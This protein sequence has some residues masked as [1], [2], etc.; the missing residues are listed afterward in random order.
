[1]A[2]EEIRGER[3]RK[4][5]ALKKAGINPYPGRTD[6]RFRIADII[7]D[8]AGYEASGEEVVAAGRVMAHREQ[9]R[10]SFADLHDESGKIQLILRSDTLDDTSKAVFSNLDIGDIIEAKGKAITTKRGEKSLEASRLVMLTKTIL[11]LPDKWHGLVDIEERLRRRYLDLL[12]NP[13]ERELFVKKS[14]FWQ[15]TR[16]FLMKEGFLEVETPVLEATPGGADAEPFLTHHNALDVDFYLRI[17]PELHLKRLLTA[18]YE[19]VFEIGRIFRN[20]G[21]DKEHLQDYTQMEVYWAFAD[22][23]M[24]MRLVGHMYKEIIAAVLGGLSQEWQ[25]ETINWENDWP[26]LDYYEIFARHTGLDLSSISDEDMKSYAETEGIDTEAHLGRGRLIDVIFKKKV[27][28]HLVQP[29]FLVLPPIEVEPLAKRSPKDPK[30]VERFQ[31]VACA[32]ELGKG[33]SELNDPLDQRARFEEQQKMRDA[34]DAEAQMM[35]VDFV[36][37]LEYGMP[38]AAGFGF[39]ERLFAILVNRPVRE[40]IF[41][42]LMRPRKSK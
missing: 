12:M 7:K 21:I 5:E 31:V 22:Y 8:F 18:G 9:G 17:S 23:E 35:D 14:K 28:P 19:R 42:P 13:E 15:A 33:F 32:S 20:E 10:V 6:R 40:A 34:G 3:I 16:T 41:F 37:A 1:M 27:R 4:L 26:K 2:L 29:G 11:P 39:S 24:M 30:R 38:P 25:G 36:E